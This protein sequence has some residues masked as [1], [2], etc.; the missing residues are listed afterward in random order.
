MGRLRLGI[1]P[2]SW[3][4]RSDDQD[5]NGQRCAESIQRTSRSASKTCRN[6]R[7]R[8]SR[9]SP[10]CEQPTL[11]LAPQASL[12]LDEV[13]LPDALRSVTATK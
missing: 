8:H 3:D 6:I 2:T 12:T 10:R 11:N 5:F 7:R 13:K 9:R 4:G 1:T